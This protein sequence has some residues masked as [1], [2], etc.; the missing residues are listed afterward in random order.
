MNKRI[1]RIAKVQPVQPGET[2]PRGIGII[3]P[4]D[5][6]MTTSG[7][8]M[9]ARRR[10]APLPNARAAG[11]LDFEYLIAPAEDWALDVLR[12]AKLKPDGKPS[13]RADTRENDAQ[14]FL[15]YIRTA[16]EKIASGDSA[17]AASIAVV[18]GAFIREAQLDHQ[19]KSHVRGYDQ[20]L[21]EQRRKA[22][23]GGLAKG[24]LETDR[25]KM[26]LTAIIESIA[27]KVYPEGFDAGKRLRSDDLWPELF[28]ELEHL[29][30][31]PTGEDEYFFTGGS[32]KY[33]TFKTM[34]WTIRNPQRG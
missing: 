23:L 16:R 8:G 4:G 9:T 19:W 12:S 1:L 5:D 31:K 18:L 3:E 30:L 22:R 29:G 10:A 15:D 2:W 6:A 26:N 28:S 21:D 11:K 32:I 7:S 33:R 34:L 17:G 27:F 24:N 20:H 25:G 13:G 14:R